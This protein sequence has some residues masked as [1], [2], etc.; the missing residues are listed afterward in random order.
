M[1]RKHKIMS[2]FLILYRFN[3]LSKCVKA[4]YINKE[5]ERIFL[6]SLRV[7]KFGT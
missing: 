2:C 4:L 3:M 5:K 6:F 7:P 1:I